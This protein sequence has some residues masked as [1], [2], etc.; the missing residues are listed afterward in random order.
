MEPALIV[1]RWRRYGADRLYVRAGTGAP[2][3]SIDLVT[4][5]VDLAHGAEWADGAVR[6][7][8]QAFLR[9]D[10]PE[11]VLPLSEVLGDGGS[12]GRRAAPGP[13]DQMAVTPAPMPGFATLTGPVLPT[14]RGRHRADAAPVDPGDS[15][16][17]RLDR[18]ELSGWSVLRDVP[19]GRQ[20]TVLDALVIGPGGA[21]ALADA[22][23]ITAS[24]F[25]L[26]GRRLSADGSAVAELREVRLAA[27][28]AGALLRA[29]VGTPVGVRGVLVVGAPVHELATGDALALELDAVPEF[30]ELLPRRWGAGRVSALTQVARRASTWALTWAH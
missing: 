13:T 9:R 23:R 30:F 17:E 10:L 20:G 5:A 12:R 1:H 15:L 11:L 24:G 3:G 29:A 25:V 18:L 4:G 8:A 7:A 28:R 6:S 16:R 21:F 26:D 27:G 22:T 2:M 14:P 19:V